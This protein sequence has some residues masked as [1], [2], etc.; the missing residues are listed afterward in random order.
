MTALYNFSKR[1]FEISACDITDLVETAKGDGVPSGDKATTEKI[2]QLKMHSQLMPEWV[3]SG[4]RLASGLFGIL[5][6]GASVGVLGGIRNLSPTTTVIFGLFAGVFGVAAHDGYHF[7]QGL[8]AKLESISKFIKNLKPKEPQTKVERLCEL[9][10]GEYLIID[11]A[12]AEAIEQQLAESSELF[13][14][15]SLIPEPSTL[16][17]V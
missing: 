13:K 7:S 9:I 14:K 16:M 8:A 2:I 11:K 15:M 6:L 17:K 1:V 3:L 5:F 4:G 10:S 12:I